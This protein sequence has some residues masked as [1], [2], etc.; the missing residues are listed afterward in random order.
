MSSVA[1]AFVEAD[2]EHI[3][4]LHRSEQ[5]GRMLVHRVP[6]EHVVYFRSEDATAEMRRGW[7][8]DPLCRGYRVE[9]DWLR[10]RWRGWGARRSVVHQMIDLGIPTFEGDVGPVKRWL[11]DHPEVAI[12][13]PR[14]C[15][16][17]IETDSRVHPKHARTEGARILVWCVVA[18][19][20]G[21]SW[22]G[23]LEEDEDAAERALLLKLYEALAPF[24]QVC[25]WNG[26]DFDFPV[27]KM[28]TKDRRINP[29]I[30]RR[31][32]RMD[33]MLVFERMN[34][35]VAESG[36]EK[37]SV[38]LNAVAQAQLGVG[39]HDFDASKTY[40]EWAAG[41]ERRER[42]VRYCVQ[43]TDLCR[44]IEQKTGYLKMH[45]TLVEICGLFDDSWALK[46]TA[47][48]DAFM[49]RLGTRRGMHFATNVRD[50][51][52]EELGQYA[53]SYNK[54]PP[55]RAGILKDVH[56]IDFSGMYPSI[57]VSWNISPDTIA[58][59]PVNGPIPEGMCRAPKTGACFDTARTGLI[60]EAIQ[61]FIDE[62]K[63]YTA[64]RDS[65]TPGTEEAHDAERWTNGFKVAPN[66]MYGA[67]GNIYCRFHVRRNAES[68]STTG[69]WLSQKTELAVEERG[70]RDIYVDTDGHYLVGMTSEQ[71]RETVGWL[72]QEFYPGLLAAQGCRKNLI[73]IAYEKSYERIVF[74]GA[75]LYCARIAFYKGKPATEET[76]P[77]I[78]GLAYKR[79]DRTR[80][81]MYMQAEAIG[82]L[83]GGIREIECGCGSRY[84]MNS[85]AKAC[86]SC[87]KERGWIARAPSPSEDVSA[88]REM[89]GRWR[90]RILE[91]ALA[92]DD[93]V[94][95]KSLSKPLADYVVRKSTKGADCSQPAHVRVAK[96]LE[97]RGE[98]VGDGTRIGYVV[99]DGA[100]TP[101]TVIPAADYSGDCDRRH[102]WEQVWG[103]TRDLL[104]SAFPVQE[105]REYDPPKREKKQAMGTQ[106][107]L[108]AKAPS[109]SR[110][111][112]GLF[113][114]ARYPS[115]QKEEGE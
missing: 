115:L 53:G 67:Q 52:R 77:E 28:R 37:Q 81:A 6:A 19:E 80:F 35:Q 29:N 79:G 48:M 26:D 97:A 76:R 44:R 24:D 15:Y 41:G 30:L 21:E 71:V 32:L 47:Q 9:G 108:S 99:V 107:V 75:K 90:A 23:V 70:A 10:T 31:W 20:T 100:A 105:W 113:D 25:A 40:E 27:V 3:A 96:V 106:N 111:Q 63:R 4:L 109:A 101:Q 86:A 12:Q 74:V 78:K 112:G 83:M 33:H 54:E 92:L 61:H 34:K 88:Y 36:E 84:A 17:D 11:A 89:V 93:I 94:T 51:E 60:P 65:L 42:L 110:S 69:A 18:D 57:M 73:K 39:K 98:D 82:L 5:D 59:G 87:G 95:V 49:L 64:L 114:V 46:P 43:D 8:K 58:D 1:N 14:R 2:E 7:K 102:L 103:P 22:T 50:A 72:N 55:R 13:R 45:Q 16:L 91:G 85:T 56:V 104:E 68:I 38:A 62:R 66:S